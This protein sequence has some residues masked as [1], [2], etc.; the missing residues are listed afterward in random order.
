VSTSITPLIC[1]C[2]L[3]E[4]YTGVPIFPGEN[5]HE[6]LACIMEILG[7]PDAYLVNKA[8]RKKMFF[9]ECQSTPLLTS[10][11]T[12]APRPFVNA[13]GKRRRPSTKTLASALKCNDELFLDFI[14]KCLTWDPDKRLKPASALR[15]AWIV[16]GRRRP[17]V[18]PA[19]GSRSSSRGM[20]G[21]SG[22]A[23]E[24]SSGAGAKG[25]VISSPTPLIAR[26]VPA[27]ASRAVQGQSSGS[28]L[29]PV[30]QV[31]TAYT[32]GHLLGTVLTVQHGIKASLG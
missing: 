3:A 28:R 9:G 30:G 17:P 31:R 23:K 5:E 29:P 15:H 22:H 8:S 32:V 24:R 25:L 14:A 19:T 21:I 6:Q 10:D 11:A 26:Q 20:E 16:S 7:V 1:S 2:I 13:K 18:A 12:G 4:L 27:S